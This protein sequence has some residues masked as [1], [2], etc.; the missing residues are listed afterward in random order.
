MTT[1]TAD[2]PEAEDLTAWCTFRLAAAELAELK[3]HAHAARISTSEL[4]RRRVLGLSPPKAAVPSINS[5][6]YAELGRIGVN[7]NQLTR[8]A[9]ET[10]PQMQPLARVLAELKGLLDRV[11]MEVIGA[12]QASEEDQE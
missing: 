10:G 4:V 3:D 2:I 1:L 8:V 6:T 5:Q 12:N 11:R 9:H 7:L